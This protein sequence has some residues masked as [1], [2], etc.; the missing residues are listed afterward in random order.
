MPYLFRFIGY[1]DTKQ[2][3]F[4]I[5]AKFWHSFTL[6]FKKNI[7]SAKRR[8]EM[9]R[10]NMFNYI[11]ASVPSWNAFIIKA[12]S[13]LAININKYGDIA[14][15][16]RIPL[17]GWKDGIGSPLHL[18]LNEIEVTHF[19]TLFTHHSLNPIFIN[20]ASKKSHSTLSYAFFVSSFSAPWNFF[21]LFLTLNWW[22][23]SCTI[24]ILS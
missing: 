7:E 12:E 1:P 24:K 5:I 15:P 21:L 4:K 18:A 6:P 3:L 11:P 2:Y 14:S 22:N 23:N 10:Q 13:L 17:N 9:T 19:I 16:F 8:W 20:Q